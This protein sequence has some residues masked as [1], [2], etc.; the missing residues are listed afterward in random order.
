MKKKT[1]RLIATI[2]VTLLLATLCSAF[3]QAYAWTNISSATAGLSISGNTG[4]AACTLSTFN[5]V[6]K[7]TVKCN[8]Q[9][10]IGS[11]WVTIASWEKNV[12]G[13]SCDVG[14]NK[15]LT[16]GYEY[17]VEGIFTAKSSTLTETATLYSVVKT[18]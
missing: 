1:K 4:Y 6:T 8:L 10:K 17:R 9:Q 5:G 15:V 18:Y 16:K 11:S 13:R 14:G 2:L 3:L 12:D 7:V